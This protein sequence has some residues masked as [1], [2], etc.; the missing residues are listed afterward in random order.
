[1]T[2]QLQTMNG[3]LGDG[4]V[5]TGSAITHVYRTNGTFTIR[6][7]VRDNTG[8]ES[9]RE[10]GIRVE[11]F[12]QGNSE[13]EIERLLDRFFTRFDKI[14][15]WSTEDIVDGWST[16]PQCR[17]RDREIAIIEQ[18]KLLI[19]ENSVEVVDMDVLVKPNGLDANATVRAKFEWRRK[20]RRYRQVRCHS[21]FLVNLRRRRMAN[22]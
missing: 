18:Q 6:L 1:M 11:R 5:R 10:Q 19:A 8:L 15:N 17:G 7:T 22:L 4:N 20:G 14:E 9:M 16:S 13:E 12:N 3:H 21:S 2:A